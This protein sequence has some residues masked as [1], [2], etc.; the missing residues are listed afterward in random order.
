MLNIAIGYDIAAHPGNDPE[1]HSYL[2]CAIALGFK[3]LPCPRLSC[4]RNPDL[5]QELYVRHTDAE[6]AKCLERFGEYAEAIEAHGAGIARFKRACTTFGLPNNAW[7]WGV[8]HAPASKARDA[9][10]EWAEW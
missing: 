3:L 2:E 4:V 7:Y 5:D 10:A 6:L 8:L 1:T 9:M